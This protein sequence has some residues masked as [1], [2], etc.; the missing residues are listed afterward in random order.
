MDAALEG[1]QPLL[2]GLIQE[3]LARQLVPGVQ[4]SFRERPADVVARIGWDIRLQLVA[5]AGRHP[6]LLPGVGRMLV[7]VRYCLGGGQHSG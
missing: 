5:V 7:V 2:V 4:H 1:L 3:V 6:R